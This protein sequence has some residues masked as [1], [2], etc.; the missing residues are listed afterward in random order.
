[1]GSPL[2]DTHLVDP[3]RS[4]RLMK[5]ANYTLPRLLKKERKLRKKFVA[6]PRTDWELNPDT[7]A[8]VY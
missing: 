5:I 3:I 8:R 4:L 1:S 7:N 6:H 2:P